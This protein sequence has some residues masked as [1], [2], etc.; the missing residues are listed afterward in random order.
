M[1]E[2]RLARGMTQ[3]QLAEACDMH[4]NSISAIERGVANVSYLALLKISKA[5]GT[6][7]EELLRET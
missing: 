1:R 3:E 6:A 4:V 2:L 7:T 5:L